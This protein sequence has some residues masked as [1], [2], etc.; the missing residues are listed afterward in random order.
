MK[1]LRGVCEDWCSIGKQ[2]AIFSKFNGMPNITETLMNRGVCLGLGIGGGRLD[3]S[4]HPSTLKNSKRPWLPLFIV[5][6]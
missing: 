2:L 3:I 5:I 6:P 4:R 1:P